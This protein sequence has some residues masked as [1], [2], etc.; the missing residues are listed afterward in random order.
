MQGLSREIVEHK[1]P[2]KKGY[3]PYKQSA[4][5]LKRDIGLTNNQLIDLS[6]VLYYKSKKI[7][8]LLKA[9]FIR[10]IRYIDWVSNI[11]PIRKKNGKLRVCIDLRN[12]NM[13]TPKDEY[14]MP[15]ADMLVD[16]AAGHEILSLM[17][18]H[19]SYNQIFIAEEDVAKTAFRC[20]G[21][22]GTFEWVV[23]SFGLKNVGATYQRVMNFIFHDLIGR[24][25]EVYIDN[26]V[27]KI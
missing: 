11:V 23:M 14:L 19:A 16:S 6:R 15:I 27:C 24:M 21:S 9:D 2:I 7:E 18:R 4:H 3:R 22:I 12:L 8:N 10:V 17:D 26:I 20:P 5:R 25:L 13:P 1:L